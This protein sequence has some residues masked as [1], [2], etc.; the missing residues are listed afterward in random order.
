MG[1]IEEDEM[2]PLEESKIN[3]HNKEKRDLKV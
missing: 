2:E 3:N 1:V